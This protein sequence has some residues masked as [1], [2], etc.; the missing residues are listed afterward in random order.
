M[1]EFLGKINK[2]L[3]EG[4]IS[5]GV[6]VSLND[7]AVSELI[8]MA[9]FDFVWIEGEHAAFGYKDIQLHMIAAHA[10]GAAAMVRLTDREASTVKP[11]LDMGPEIIAFPW[12]NSAEDAKEA[13]S[14]CK[15]PPEGIRGYNPQRAGHYG[16][17][18]QSTYVEHADEE[19]KIWMIIEQKAGFEN[20][21]EIISVKG[22]DG[23]VLGPGDL[24]VDLGTYGNYTKEVDSYVIAAAETCM[25]K[26]MPFLV[27][28]SMYDTADYSKWEKLG[29]S[30]FCFSQ[31]TH[32][33]SRALMNVWPV[34]VDGVP[35][36]R[37]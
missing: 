1:K 31:D 22:V 25:R 27:F 5:C 11:V 33:L 28:P 29:A 34:F 26:N 8:G 19:T 21:D 37:R 24:S 32:F 15:Y 12:I 17:M 3:E 7:S 2:K 13:V 18:G 4:R 16:Q 36:K 9:G 6:V 30:F 14:V 23:V 20:I 35:E 10:G